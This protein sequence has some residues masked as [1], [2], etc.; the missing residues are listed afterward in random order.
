MKTPILLFATILL[1][2]CMGSVPT[3]STPVDGP[4]SMIEVGREF[5]TYDFKDPT[6]AQFRGESLYRLGN[7]DFAVCGQVNGKNSFGAY[8]GFQPYYVRLTAAGA[9]VL[10]RTDVLAEQ[11]CR[12]LSTGTI[13]LRA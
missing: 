5:V 12:Q 8:N 11:G 1:S 4:N 9:G 2:G 13:N 7:G 3:S 6:S 10:K